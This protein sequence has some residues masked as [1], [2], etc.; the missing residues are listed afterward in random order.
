MGPRC[1]RPPVGTIRPVESCRTVTLAL[2]SDRVSREPQSRQSLKRTLAPGPPLV[3]RGS[4]R[5][6]P[7]HLGIDPRYKPT[8]SANKGGTIGH[9]ARDCCAVSLSKEAVRQHPQDCILHLDRQFGLSQER[10]SRRRNPSENM[11]WIDNWRC[12]LARKSIVPVGK[13]PSFLEERVT[14]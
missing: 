12:S 5:D 6:E 13:D 2:D 10:F 1:G 14:L 4:K 11:A 8:R 9:N 7:P 3:V